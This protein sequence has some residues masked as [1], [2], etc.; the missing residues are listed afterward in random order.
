[1]RSVWELLY[2][3]FVRDFFKTTECRGLT[4]SPRDVQLEWFKKTENY[5]DERA[6]NVTGHE[7]PRTLNLGN[8]MIRFEKE[9]LQR[10]IKGKSRVAL[11]INR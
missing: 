3:I 1:M 10:W 9:R 11:L 4:S 8:S 6:Y 7:L 2:E 5:W